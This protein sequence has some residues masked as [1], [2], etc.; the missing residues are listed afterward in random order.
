MS[1]AFY[2]ITE[3][4]QNKK[5]Y[6]REKSIIWYFGDGGTLGTEDWVVLWGRRIVIGGLGLDGGLGLRI[7]RSD[8]GKKFA[9]L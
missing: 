4:I 5:G 8:N 6:G 7:K 3:Y 2:S 1:K 9:L